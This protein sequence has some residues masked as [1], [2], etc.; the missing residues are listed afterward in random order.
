MF[1]KAIKTLFLVT[2]LAI[3]FFIGW[4]YHSYR[5]TTK[6]TLSGQDIVSSA[7]EILSLSV[8]EQNF[9][10][11]YQ[12][13]KGNVQIYS[14]E[15]PFTGQESLIWVSGKVTAGYDLEKIQ[16]DVINDQKKILISQLEPVVVSLETN[17]QYLSE[18][19]SFVSRIQV[20]DRNEQM[21]AIRNKIRQEFQ[22]QLSRELIKDR[23]EKLLGEFSKWSGYQMDIQ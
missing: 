20:K 17:F 2:F 11:I 6:S 18:K 5:E 21:E 14:F 22:N 7:K 4:F 13:K 15:I 10:T 3:A 23:T 19:D 16:I 1:S 8:L 9:Q 12:A